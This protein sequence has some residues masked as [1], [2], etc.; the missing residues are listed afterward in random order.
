MSGF[1]LLEMIMVLLLIGLLGAL[2]APVFVT[3]LR[4][5]VSGTV[6]QQSADEAY[7]AASRMTSIIRRAVS[8]DT[9]DP[10]APSFDLIELSGGSVETNSYSF[11]FS[12]GQIMY[13]GI[14]FWDDVHA[15]S[16]SYNDGL[17]QADI[18]LVDADH[19]VISLKIH[20]RNA[21]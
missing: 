18:Q 3:V 6:E 21:L 1:S 12:N 14:L 13:D 8:A 20:V 5:A 9:S 10:Q 19:P 17:F 7:W 2:T 15:F 16:S 11:V 4:G